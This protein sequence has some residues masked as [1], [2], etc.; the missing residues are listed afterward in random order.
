MRIWLIKLLVSVALSL[1]MALFLRT[2]MFNDVV[3]EPLMG[4]AAADRNPL[5]ELPAA[6]AQVQ[7]QPTPTAA[8]APESASET[9]AAPALAVAPRSLTARLS[10]P[11]VPG[12]KTTVRV[13]RSGGGSD[14]RRVIRVGE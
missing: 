14:N 7:A 8:Q 13:N 2:D 6:L 11:P 3:V 1:A 5:R 9:A 10:E 4:A 12:G